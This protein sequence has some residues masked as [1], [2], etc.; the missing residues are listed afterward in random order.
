ML[1]SSYKPCS[2][3]GYS[4]K[5]TINTNIILNK[6]YNSKYLASFNITNQ[7]NYTQIYTVAIQNYKYKA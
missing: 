5:T 3:E 1:I 7:Y 2:C 6:S 4:T